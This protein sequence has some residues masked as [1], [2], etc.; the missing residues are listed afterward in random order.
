MA[1]AITTCELSRSHHA[2]TRNASPGAKL[3]LVQHLEEASAECSDPTVD[4]EPQTIE[5]FFDSFLEG[6]YDATEYACL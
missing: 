5:P 1:S 3:L 6:D 4:N 2:N